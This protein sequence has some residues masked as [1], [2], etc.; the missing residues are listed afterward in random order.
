MAEQAVLAD[1][2]AE[3]H[4]ARH[5]RNMRELYAERQQV[6]LDLAG[7]ELGELLLFRRAAAG[8]R[9]V[10]CLPP[11][12]LD[13]QVALHAAQRGVVVEPLS[14]GHGHGSG[15]Q[16]LVFGYAQFHAAQIRPAM[17]TLADILRLGR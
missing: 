1:F 8:I 16:G 6:F 14:R 4:F 12:M 3:G 10:G 13:Q 11:G 2:I 9:L 17:G 5:A 7:R 15:L